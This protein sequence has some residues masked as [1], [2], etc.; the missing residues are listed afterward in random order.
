MKAGFILISERNMVVQHG[1]QPGKNSH[2]QQIDDYHVQPGFV[3]AGLGAS[4]V[5][6]VSNFSSQNIGQP[7]IAGAVPLT[8]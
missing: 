4:A 7:P 2:K 6:A 1:A 3:H 5:P 8:R